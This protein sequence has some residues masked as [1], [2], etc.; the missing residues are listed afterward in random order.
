MGSARLT[1][2]WASSASVVLSEAFS[3]T[4]IVWQTARIRTKS[5][6]ALL[7]LSSESPSHS[8]QKASSWK[9][10]LVMPYFAA[11][12]S[13]ATSSGL[14]LLGADTP[15]LRMPAENFL[16]SITFCV[17]VPVLSEKM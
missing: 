6:R 1:D 8:G 16:K 7:S 17:S 5:S 14:V 11:F 3:S 13:L 12:S 15:K 9:L 2:A 4:R 10:T